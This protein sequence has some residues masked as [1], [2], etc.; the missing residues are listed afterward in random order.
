M[1]IFLTELTNLALQSVCSVLFVVGTNFL[2]NKAIN[3]LQE[4]IKEFIHILDRVAT[5]IGWQYTTC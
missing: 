5:V 3:V 1:T 4:R 2:Y